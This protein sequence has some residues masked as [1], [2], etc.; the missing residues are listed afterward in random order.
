[1]NQRLIPLVDALLKCDSG[2]WGNDPTSSEGV[3]VLRV[4]DLNSNNTISYETAPNRVIEDRKLREKSLRNGDILVVKSSGSATNVVTGRAVLVCGIGDQT[5]SFSNF[6]VR[7][8]ANPDDCLPEYLIHVLR[9]PQVRNF[10][11]SMVSGSTYPNLSLPKYRAMQIPVVNLDQ[12]RNIAKFMDR[13]YASIAIAKRNAE[14]NV[15]NSNNI[16]KGYLDSVFRVVNRE[17][18]SSELQVRTLKEVLHIKKGRKPNLHQDQQNGDIP[19]LVAKVL[20][21]SQR[22]EWVSRDDPR[23]VAVAANETII[24]CDGSNSGEVF[25]GFSGAISSTMAKVQPFIPLDQAYLRWFLEGKADLLSGSKTGA[26]IPHLD[27]EIFF[28]LQIPLPPIAEQHAIATR[29]D[30]LEA[31]VLQL[32]DIY[33]RKIAALEQLERSLLHQVFSGELAAA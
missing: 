31:I 10:V 32:S 24:I 8:R 2:E 3:P 14:L 5:I 18:V 20:R 6:L 33:D 17:S 28:N 9:S 13:A 29:L 1:M 30:A 26:A 16:L 22:P 25:S 7:L 11:L 23:A 21:G 15:R 19:Y 4:A 27:Q 12:Q